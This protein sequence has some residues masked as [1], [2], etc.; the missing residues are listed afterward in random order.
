MD[1]HFDIIRQNNKKLYINKSFRNTSFEQALLI[2]KEYLQKHFKLT[3]VTSS[4]FCRVYKLVVRF[5]NVDTC[6]YLKEHLSRGILDTIKHIIR[7]GRAERAFDASLMLQSN[8]FDAPIVIALLER[9]LGLFRTG[10]VLIT[11]EVENAE[12]ILKSLTDS[13]P[14]RDSALDRRHNLI[15]GFG[16]TIGQMH[17][18]GIFHGD[19]RAGNIMV[20]DEKNNW[21]FFFLDNERTR[22]F[23]KLSARLRVKNL[24]Q[25][26]ISSTTIIGN[27]DRMR[28]YKRYLVEN[29]MSRMEGKKLAKKVFKKTIRRLRGR[30]EIGNRSNKYLKTNKKFLRIENDRYLAVFDKSLC[31]GA[32]P[33]DFIEKT[34]AL[35]D[36]GT[37]IKSDTTAYLSL[38][39]WNNK[40]VVIKR[41]NH[42]GLIHSLRHTIKGSRAKRSWLNGQLLTLLN[43]PTPKPLAFIEQR[44]G[45]LLWKSYLVTEYVDGRQLYHFLRNSSITQQQRSAV[46]QQVMDLL[47][48]LSQYR[49]SHG[50]LKPSNILL[51][52][53][54]P[55]LTDL[56]GMKVYRWNWIHRA[57]QIKDITRLTK[58]QDMRNISL[59]V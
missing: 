57:R 8:G 27:T 42:K 32:D 12:P 58:K 21:R 13:C 26:Q 33:I 40:E 38:V 50:D 37:I 29:T 41:Y 10:G 59:S 51:T 43:I 16:Q 52:N 48:N 39:S 25:L 11:K 1:T 5:N 4:H 6:L 9:R 14:N 56:D 18:D 34:D 53:D 31:E 35:M 20:R 24:V 46:T 54:G 3:A 30:T 7:P 45:L 55:V 44:K 47:N 49:I 15:A 2:G 36:N 28:F 17:A 19:L 22:K 23:Q